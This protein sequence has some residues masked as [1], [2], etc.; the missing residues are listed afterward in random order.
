MFLCA[1]SSAALRSFTANDPKF[2]KVR[3]RISREV[4]ERKGSLYLRQI[5]TSPR[6]K[7]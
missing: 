1:S 4:S 7:N 2:K 5:F 3:T 6:R